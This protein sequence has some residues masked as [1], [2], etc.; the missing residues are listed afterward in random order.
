M[1]DVRCH[2]VCIGQFYTRIWCLH[3]GFT[4]RTDDNVAHDVFC[5]HY[6][7]EVLTQYS[8]PTLEITY[9]SRK[10]T[11]RP[12]ISKK[13]DRINYIGDNYLMR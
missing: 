8:K 10:Q 7:A 1:H 2:E 5:N 4:I 11:K 6:I 13:N 9:Y 3:L 12:T